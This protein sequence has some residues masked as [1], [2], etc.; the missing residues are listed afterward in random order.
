MATV[1]NI[2]IPT[3][4]I[5]VHFDW[6]HDYFSISKQGICFTNP[7][8]FVTFM[9]GMYSQEAVNFKDVVTSSAQRQNF[10]LFLLQDCSNTLVNE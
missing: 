4:L 2:T 7:E 5:A 1:K 3:N 10:D 8:W 9:V 6:S